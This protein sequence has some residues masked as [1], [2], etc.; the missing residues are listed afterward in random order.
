MINGQCYNP[1]TD[2]ELATIYNKAQDLSY[3]L[4]TTKPSDYDTQ[5]KIKAKIIA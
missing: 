4:N 3:E 5:G 1:V 2:E